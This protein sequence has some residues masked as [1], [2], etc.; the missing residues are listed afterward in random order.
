MTDIIL[1]VNKSVTNAL[2]NYTDNFGETGLFIIAGD[3]LN[4]V[5]LI[6]KAVYTHLE[7]LKIPHQKN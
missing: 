6:L 7:D 1:K 5:K 4:D 3:N 2:D